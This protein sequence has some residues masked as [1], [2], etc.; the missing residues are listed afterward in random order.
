MARCWIWTRSCCANRQSCDCAS[1]L[2][3]TTTHAAR[4]RP[5]KAVKPPARAK[6]L[7]LRIRSR[8]R[9]VH[10]QIT[11]PIEQPIT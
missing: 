6:A 4:K 11:P 8:M 10:T 3:S 2:I 9:S 5:A 7:G 1:G